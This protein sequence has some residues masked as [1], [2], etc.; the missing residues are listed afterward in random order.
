MTGK[1]AGA[2]A[3]IQENSN[4][5]TNDESELPGQEAEI[6]QAPAPDV[7]MND[8]SDDQ[9]TDSDDAL[10]FS[11]VYES[12]G[13]DV[14]Y[15]DYDDNWK[16]PGLLDAPDEPRANMVQRWVSTMQSGRP[17]TANLS[18]RYN[19][20][21]RPRDPSTCPHGIKPPTISHGQFEGAIGVEGNVLMERPA[22]LHAKFAQAILAKTE[23][24]MASVQES[25]FKMRQ[26]GDSKHGFHK[27]EVSR[28]QRV[29]RSG[30]TV[31]PAPDDD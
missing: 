6:T 21:W 5:G 7:D 23:K 31:R 10:D 11:R 22:K 3:Q 18:K 29:S 8:V 13:D 25:L 20:G 30:S 17:D 16:P 26:P 9:E 27:P 14:E 1:A 4:P 12:Y 19:E 15:E 2:L 24:Q 28:D